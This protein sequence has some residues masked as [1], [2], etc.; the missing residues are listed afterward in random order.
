MDKKNTIKCSTE[1]DYK[2][3]RKKITVY[4]SMLVN[5]NFEELK[6]LSK[7]EILHSSATS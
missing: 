6:F 7:R 3:H 4:N 1:N 5:E 2:Y